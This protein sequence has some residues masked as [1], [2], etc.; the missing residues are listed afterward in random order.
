MRDERGVAAAEFALCLPFLLVLIMGI[1]DFGS[2][3]YTYMQVNA[4][5]N[6]GAQWVYAN[7]TCTT[8]SVSGAVSGSVNAT[9][10][11]TPAPVCGA[12]YCITNNVLVSTAGSTCASGDAVGY[13]AVVSARAAVT[14]LAPWSSLVMP[15]SLTASAA[16][17]Y[18]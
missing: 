12:T 16:I 8:G 11:A 1:F 6:A 15:S 13:Y 14:P 9:V 17:R 4:A 3:A 10:T 2:L 5:A 7:G 18:Q